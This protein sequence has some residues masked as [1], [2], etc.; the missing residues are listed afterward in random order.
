MKCCRT[1]VLPFR[2]ATPP[3]NPVIEV[4]MSDD[5]EVTDSLIAE[6]DGPTPLQ[7]MGGDTVAWWRADLGVTLNVG[8]VSSWLDQGPDAHVLAQASVPAQS[9]FNATGG[10]NSRQSI[11]FN[12]V[13][14]WLRNTTINRPAPA[15]QV[16]LVWMIF[17]QVTWT[18]TRH[19]CGF[20]TDPNILRTEQATVSPRIRQ[21]NGLFGNTNDSLPINTYGRMENGFSGSAADYLKLIGTTS[22][23]LNSGNFDPAAGFSLAASGNEQQRSNIEVC[24]LAIFSAFPSVARQAQLDA[25]VTARYGAG[26]V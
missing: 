19:I 18:G 7:I 10:P 5:I 1:K 23:G 15:T 22:T 16:T 3:V 20:G 25:Y 14:Q 17:R 8:N 12:G 11:L 4:S 13:D 2:S 9:V 26:L 21:T 6:L 24:E